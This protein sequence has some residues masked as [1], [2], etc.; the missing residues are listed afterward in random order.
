M[1][2]YRGLFLL[3][4]VALQ[5]AIAFK[6]DQVALNTYG[7]IGQALFGGACWSLGL[8]TQSSRMGRLQ[9]RTASKAG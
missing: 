2:R 9:E 7:E 1:L 8:T 3:L 6:I 5:L 4:N